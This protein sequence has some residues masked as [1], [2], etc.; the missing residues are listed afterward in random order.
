MDEKLQMLEAQADSGGAEFEFMQKFQEMEAKDSM[1]QEI[2]D[3]LTEEIEKMQQLL[4]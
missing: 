2:I 4:A 3:E 1:Q